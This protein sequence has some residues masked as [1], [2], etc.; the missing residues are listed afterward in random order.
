MYK[1]TKLIH[2]GTVPAHLN[3]CCVQEIRQ[4]SEWPYSTTIIIQSHTVIATRVLIDTK[5]EYRHYLAV[6]H[7]SSQTYR[8]PITNLTIIANGCD[9]TRKPADQWYTKSGQVG[10]DYR[11][12]T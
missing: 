7:T 9:V 3:H 12:M 8:E 1:S 10:I 4:Y 2:K 6:V 11:P 5:V